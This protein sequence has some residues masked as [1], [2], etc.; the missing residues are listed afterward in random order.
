MPIGGHAERP[1]SHSHRLCDLPPRGSSWP[2]RATPSF[3]DSTPAPCS[4]ATSTTSSWS[5][6]GCSVR[7]ESSS[8]ATERLAWG[9]IAA[10]ILAW[11]FGEIYYTGVLWT[12]PA[13]PVPS[14]ADAGYLLFPTLMLGGLIVLLRSR[15]ARHAGHPARRWPDGGAGDRRGRRRDRLSDRARFRLRRSA[16]NRQRPSAT[17]SPTS[18]SAASSSVPWAAPAGAW[19]ARG[20][21]SAPASSPSGSPTPSTSSRSPRAPTNRQAGSTPAGGSA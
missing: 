10:G 16:R 5:P 12:N 11:T 3:P 18:C 7:L 8:S 9:L 19:T 17:R 20:P 13:P 21:C 6:W 1:A 14:P 2:P 15:I 4:A